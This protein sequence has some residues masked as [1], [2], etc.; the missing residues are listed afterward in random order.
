MH[1]RKTYLHD[2]F[3][4]NRV[5]RS[6]KTVHTIL[7]AQYRKL[8]KFAT[9][10]SNFEKNQ[11][12]WTC[13]IRKHTCISIFNKIGLK[14]NSWPCSQVYRKKIA[15]CINLQLPIIIFKNRLFQTCI[16]V[17]RNC[18]SIFSKIGLVDQ[19]KPCT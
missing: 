14:H 1:H 10:D 5:S 18:I 4:Q 2:D 6:V 13:I 15:S 3:Q 12:F 11:S 16:M 17:K 7:F 9:T 19:S 8:H